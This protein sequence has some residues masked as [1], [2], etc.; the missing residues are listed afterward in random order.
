[1]KTDDI[2]QWINDPSQLNRESMLQLKS[3]ME[4]YPCFTIARMLYLKSLLNLNDLHFSASLIKTAVSVPDRRRLYYFIE[5]KS[6][7]ERLENPQAAPLE[8]GGFSLIDR[9]LQGSTP[10]MAPLQEEAE[11]ISY[12][13]QEKPAVDELHVAETLAAEPSIQPEEG[14]VLNYAEFLSMQPEAE[15]TE[16]V[17]PMIG[18]E[19]IDQFLEQ[20]AN[21]NAKIR[22]KP[23][24][25][26]PV[27]EASIEEVAALEQMVSS[28]NLPEDSFTD[29]LAKIYLKQKRYDRALEIF[30]GLSLKY[31]EKNVYF[32]DQIRFL[33]KLIIHIK[34]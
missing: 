18:Q 32:A 30:K 33:E 28:F 6:L 25:E 10:T 1:M 22:L 13:P 12:I 31:P 34:K 8:S 19:L 23:E 9:F 7:P 21:N 15:P 14:F 17:Q 29:T 27:D 20:S 24:V 11:T 3:V 5:G 26:K 4:E 16:P 2:R